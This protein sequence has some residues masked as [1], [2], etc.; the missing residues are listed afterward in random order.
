ML[1]CRG[2]MLNCRGEVG[3]ATIVLMSV[4]RT[5]MIPPPPLRP[6][7][8]RIWS[9]TGRPEAGLPV[10]LPGTGA[11][12]FLHAASA[13]Q[14]PFADGRGGPLPSGH[15]L[16]PRSRLVPLGVDGP[17]D[18]VAV[19]FRVGALRHFTRVPLVELY[20][21][22]APAVEVLGN[23]T[24]ELLERLAALP[25]GAAGLRLRAELVVGWLR[26][27]LERH[28][29][30]GGEARL[31]DAALARLYYRAGREP[32][33]RASETL[34]VSP[35][36]LGRVVGR[37]PPTTPKRL[38]RLARFHHVARR[39]LLE[40]GTDVLR[41]AC[42]G[43]YYDQAHFIHEVVALTGLTPGTLFTPAARRSHFYNPRVGSPGQDRSVSG[44]LAGRV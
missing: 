40:P 29:G 42:D 21:R 26:A 30:V 34:G 7:V 22:L 24:D 44:D 3:G 16:C 23:G 5:F 20:D 33:A 8:D 41:A 25:G 27:L 1:N 9:W 19:R 37:A 18:F 2:N 4:E 36:H 28:A 32:V 10:A 15:L 13:F 14:V 11:E 6:Y 17:L 43:G 31:A 35:R 38:Q 39:L 12:L